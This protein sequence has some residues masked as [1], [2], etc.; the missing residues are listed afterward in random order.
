MWDTQ[1]VQLVDT[2]EAAYGDIPNILRFSRGELFIGW[3]S[4]KIWVLR[5]DGTHWVLDRYADL[6]NSVVA[7]DVNANGTLVALL[8][9][10][11]KSEP[12]VV[13]LDSL[14][15]T[16]RLLGKYM[17]SG[18]AGFGGVAIL[19]DGM[20]AVAYDKGKVQFLSASLE[21]MGEPVE[22]DTELMLA[23]E[24]LPFDDAVVTVGTRG[25]TVIDS[26]S[27]ENSPVRQRPFKGVVVGLTVTSD[28][29]QAATIDFGKSEIAVWSLDP[30]YLRQAACKAVGRDLT[31]EEW[32]RYVGNDV[33]PAAI[34]RQ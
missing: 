5:Y 8:A 28:E 18:P 10:S 29:K 16:L 14:D 11:R 6:F 24:R 26:Y 34:C 23:M 2:P 27:R 7:L 9:S 25:S 4:G 3:R 33:Q 21:P 15:P 32:A 20:I 19:P 31:A 17:L 12:R 13:T 22:T 30:I 1:N